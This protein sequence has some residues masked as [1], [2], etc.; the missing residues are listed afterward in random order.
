MSS[1]PFRE[2]C[3]LKWDPCWGLYGPHCWCSIKP[4]RFGSGSEDLVLPGFGLSWMGPLVEW[5][6]CFYFLLYSYLVFSLYWLFH[7]VVNCHKS[8]AINQINSRTGEIE[9]HLP[10]WMELWLGS[11]TPSHLRTQLEKGKQMS[12]QEG[13]WQAYLMSWAGIPASTCAKKFH[14]TL[15]YHTSHGWLCPLQVN[16]TSFV[17]FSIPH[18]FFQ[19]ISGYLHFKLCR[20]QG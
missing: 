16:I 15:P 11:T 8:V 7:Y 14:F 5:V 18:D 12:F 19:S 10:A 17:P 6:C 9:T 3:C 4:W 2:F 1:F 13:I 20:L